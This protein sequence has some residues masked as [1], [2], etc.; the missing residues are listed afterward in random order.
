MVFVLVCAA[1]Q[2]TLVA[3]ACSSSRTDGETLD[4]GTSDAESNRPSACPRVAPDPLSQCTV[5]E[6]TT[7]A[8]GKCSGTF[9]ACRRTRWQVYLSDASPGCPLDVPEAGSACES[10]F[11]EGRSCTYDPCSDG[12][13][14][15]AKVTCLGA[16]FQ[17][18]ASLC[19]QHDAGD[20]GDASDASDSGDASDASDGD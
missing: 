15:R 11:E 6:G 18:D 10:C 14:L 19:P 9:A 2:G 1:V 4:A 13:L 12:G 17:V 16:I 7:C 5:P 8:F 3:A 20:A